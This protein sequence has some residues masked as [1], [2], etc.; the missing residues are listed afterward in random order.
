M[1][2]ININS[3]ESY[4][5]NDLCCKAGAELEQLMEQQNSRFKLMKH[6]VVVV[7]VV[8]AVV[9]DFVVVCCCSWI[10]H[11]D[12]DM[13]VNIKPLVNSLSYFDPKEDLIYYGRSGSK[14]SKPRHVSELS[15]LGEPGKEFFFAVGGIYCLSRA[16]LEKAAPYLV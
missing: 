8:V 3:S 13:Y 16:L 14:P 12:D 6:V 15:L 2:Y 9:V 7:V 5:R 4:S 11:V 10:C 1:H